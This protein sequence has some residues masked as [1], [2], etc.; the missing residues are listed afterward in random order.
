[1]RFQSSFMLSPFFGENSDAGIGAVDL[2]AG[3]T[4]NT[5]LTFVPIPVQAFRISSGQRQ[6]GS[7]TS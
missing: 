7:E 5:M 4:A 1:M 2:Q 3:R 6:A